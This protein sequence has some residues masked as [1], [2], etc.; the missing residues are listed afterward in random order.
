MS[1][2]KII[3]DIPE[4]LDKYLNFLEIISRISKGKTF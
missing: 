4:I 1:L 2:H 3:S